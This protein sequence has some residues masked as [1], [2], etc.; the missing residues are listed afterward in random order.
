MAGWPQ[1]KYCCNPPARGG[2]PVGHTRQCNGLGQA[3]LGVATWTGSAARAEK[4]RHVEAALQDGHHFVD[5]PMLHPDYSRPSDPPTGHWGPVP[6]SRK[7]DRWATSYPSP[8]DSIQATCLHGPAVVRTTARSYVQGALEPAHWLGP[9]S[10]AD[11]AVTTRHATAGA[12]LGPVCVC[13]VRHAET[14]P[15]GRGPNS[16][17]TSPPPFRT[18]A[19]LLLIGCDAGGAPL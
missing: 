1:I 14:R 18:A 2:A 12:D 7:H 11:V 3:A 6:P 9:P 5:R 15:F 16:A 4:G 10:A 17:R 8:R 19:T 13:R